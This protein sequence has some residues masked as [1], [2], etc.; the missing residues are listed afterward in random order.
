MSDPKHTTEAAEEEHLPLPVN[1]LTEEPD[2]T[3]NRVRAVLALLQVMALPRTLTLEGEEV[4]GLYYL[5]EV[6]RSAVDFA[7]E[8]RAEEGE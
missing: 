8:Q 4:T 2:E 5:L 6:L 7:A 1:P 3:L